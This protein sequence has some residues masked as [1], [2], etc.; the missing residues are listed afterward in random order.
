[1]LVEGDM[2]CRELTAQLDVLDDDHR[3]PYFGA[4]QEL[5]VGVQ[6]IPL[7]CFGEM[8]T[9]RLEDARCHIAPVRY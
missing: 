2:E 8:E 3:W 5:E 7:S 6:D 1:M 4:I 9:C